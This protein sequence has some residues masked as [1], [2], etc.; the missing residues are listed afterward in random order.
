MWYGV[1]RQKRDCVSADYSYPAVLKGSG[2]GAGVSEA[3]GIRRAKSTW[4][5]G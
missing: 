2:I 5:G 4:R 3:G 1:Q